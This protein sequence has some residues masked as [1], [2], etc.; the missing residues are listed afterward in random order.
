MTQV[1]KMIFSPS[2][3]EQTRSRVFGQVSLIE[4]FSLLD[5]ARRDGV[6]AEPHDTTMRPSHIALRTIL[7]N[8]GSR[9]YSVSPAQ[10]E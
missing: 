1:H 3:D 4:I 7:P 9:K 6:A 2:A 5:F 10:I 8:G